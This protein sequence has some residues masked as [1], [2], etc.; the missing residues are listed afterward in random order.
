MQLRMA[1][2]YV[3]EDN[4][5]YLTVCFH[6]PTAGITGI[7]LWV[8]SNIAITVMLTLLVHDGNPATREVKTGMHGGQ[9]P[10]LVYAAV[11]THL[12]RPKIS[13]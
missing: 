8:F 3:T 10:L 7:H 11:C 1:E 13:I 9:R 4:F 12:V 2:N 5:E 6:L